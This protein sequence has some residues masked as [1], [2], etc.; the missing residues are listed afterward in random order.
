[1]TRT[2]ILLAALALTACHANHSGNEDMNVPDALSFSAPAADQT[3]PD[4][5]EDEF[6]SLFKSAIGKP[7]LEQ[8]VNRVFH[9]TDTDAEKEQEFQSNWQ[10]QSASTKSFYDR[11]SNAGNGCKADY[12]AGNSLDLIKMKKGEFFANESKGQIAGPAC[13]LI[14]DL[15]TVETTEIKTLRHAKSNGVVQNYSLYTKLTLTESANAA[16]LG[17]NYT[18]TIQYAGPTSQNKDGLKMFWNGTYDLTLNIDAQNSIKGTCSAQTLVHRQSDGSRMEAVFKCQ[19]TNP[20][21]G[22][23]I[24]YSAHLVQDKNSKLDIYLGSR[25]IDAQSTPKLLFPALIL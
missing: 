13:P 8:V 16:D 20:A 6:S 10:A 11:I 19:L 14:A 4:S 3:A 7:Q 25:Q 1:M 21:T 17:S 12:K 22:H 24:A 5:Q 18:Y 9:T 2:W 15:K 23:T